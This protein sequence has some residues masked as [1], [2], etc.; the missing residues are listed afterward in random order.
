MSSSHSLQWNSRM[1][2]DRKLSNELS[3]YSHSEANLLC[4]NKKWLWRCIISNG[5][6]LNLSRQ[7]F[8]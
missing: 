2:S 1:L 7:K 6:Y 5:F 3:A 4:R 8:S